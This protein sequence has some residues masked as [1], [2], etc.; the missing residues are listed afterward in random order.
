[1]AALSACCTSGFM[2]VRRTPIR[3][4]EVE[5]FKRPTQP[6]QPL[7]SAFGD[8]LLE[9]TSDAGTWPSNSERSTGCPSPASRSNRLSDAAGKVAREKI[10]SSDGALELI[11]RMCSS[12]LIGSMLG[13]L[14]SAITPL[15]RRPRGLS[16]TQAK[17]ESASGTPQRF[18]ATDL[19]AGFSAPASLHE[20]CDAAIAALGKQQP[21]PPPKSMLRKSAS[22]SIFVKQG[23]QSPHALLMVQSQPPNTAPEGASKT[24]NGVQMKGS[25]G[26]LSRAVLKEALGATQNAFALARDNE[27]FTSL[28]SDSYTASQQADLEAPQVGQPSLALV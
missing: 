17:P 13:R 10:S 28:L 27:S 18:K 6:W 23:R 24:G 26:L 20:A 8:A 9:T 19:E 2:T 12:P 14:A 16:D 5:S 3:S 25:E 1:M 11:K 7:K 21:P 15:S 22:G 4:G